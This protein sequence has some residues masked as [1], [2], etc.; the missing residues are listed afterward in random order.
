MNEAADGGDNR[1]S[2]NGRWWIGNAAA[3]YVR[4][5]MTQQPRHLLVS[6]LKRER[7]LSSFAHC[8]FGRYVALELGRSLPLHQP[9]A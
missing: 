4:L 5:P 8:I 9:E 6:S 3:R 2:I 7:V 1:R